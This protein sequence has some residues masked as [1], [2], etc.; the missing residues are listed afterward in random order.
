MGEVH[1]LYLRLGLLQ[2]QIPEKWQEARI[3]EVELQ[4]VE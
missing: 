3:R 2:P 4:K 1:Q